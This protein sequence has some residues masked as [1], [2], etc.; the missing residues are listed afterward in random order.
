MQARL[1]KRVQVYNFRQ[2][3]NGEQYYRYLCIANIVFRR[4]GGAQLNERYATVFDDAPTK[5]S[6]QTACMSGRPCDRTALLALHVVLHA[7]LQQS[8]Q[9]GDD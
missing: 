1:G 3:A 2:A 6:V 7:P 5:D 4:D 9:T 8:V